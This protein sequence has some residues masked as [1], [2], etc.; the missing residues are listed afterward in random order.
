MPAVLTCIVGKRLCASA[1][2][3]HWQLRQQSALLLSTLL[4]RFREKYEDL[5]PRVTMTLV[6]ANPV[7]QS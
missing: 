6:R 3:D 7:A 4:G 2:E 5:Q 1:M